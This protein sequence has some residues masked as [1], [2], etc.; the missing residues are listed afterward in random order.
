MAIII[1]RLH[2]QV[3]GAI[4]GVFLKKE[5]VVSESGFRGGFT[6]RKE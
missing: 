1:C 5:S 6:R 2:M 4:K 3:L